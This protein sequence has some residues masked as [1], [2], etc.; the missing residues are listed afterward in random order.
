[1]K[2][3]YSFEG[4]LSSVYKIFCLIPSVSFIIDTQF[5]EDYPE[6][7]LEGYTE[8][9]LLFQLFVWTFSVYLTVPTNK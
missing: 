1:M 8:Y 3:S 4:T 2:L 7:E 5:K 9:S 6:I